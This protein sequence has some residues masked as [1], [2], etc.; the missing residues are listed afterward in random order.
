MS[1]EN[2]NRNIKKTIKL[3]N[4]NQN[5]SRISSSKKAK[6]AIMIANLETTF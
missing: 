4:K 3:E 1:H 5:K 2:K 6:L